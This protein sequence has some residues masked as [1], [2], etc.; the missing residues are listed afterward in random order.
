M[1]MHYFTYYNGVD[2]IISITSFAIFDSLYISTLPGN[3][4]MGT[5]QACTQFWNT[6]TNSLVL[7]SVDS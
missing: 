2:T 5:L 6:S 3:N 1:L 4:L 7:S